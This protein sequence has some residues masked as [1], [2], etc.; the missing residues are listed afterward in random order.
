LGCDV[1]FHPPDVNIIDTCPSNADV[2]ATLFAQTH[3]S[4]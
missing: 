4:F 2:T 1:T 3:K